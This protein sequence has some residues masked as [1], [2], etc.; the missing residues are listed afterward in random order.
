MTTREAY[1]SPPSCG[2]EINSS[3][4]LSRW[5]RPQH[6]SLVGD[7]VAKCSKANAT[8]HKIPIII[9]TSLRPSRSQTTY[10]QPWPRARDLGFLVGVP[11]NW[12]L[13]AK[14]VNPERKKARGTPRLFLSSGNRNDWKFNWNSPGSIAALQWAQNMKNT[15]FCSHYSDRY[16]ERRCQKHVP[17]VYLES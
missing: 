2:V 13:S 12:T 6:S 17:R 4:D 3:V 15:A 11:E 7:V 16:L 1:A 9:Q 10:L 14:K 5:G 8:H